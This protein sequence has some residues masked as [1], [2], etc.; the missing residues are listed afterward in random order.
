MFTPIDKLNTPRQASPN[1]DFVSAA[2]KTKAVV[3]HKAVAK[4]STK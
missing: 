4:H 2:T 1:A 3:V